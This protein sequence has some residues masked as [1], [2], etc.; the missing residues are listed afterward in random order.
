LEEIKRKE[1]LK[2]KENQV[3]AE[4]IMEKK[5][6]IQTTN[7]KSITI[8]ENTFKSI[9]IENPTTKTISISKPNIEPIIITKPNGIIIS[10]DAD[11]AQRNSIPTEMNIQT[12]TENILTLQVKEP[13]KQ[14][15]HFETFQEN[16]MSQKQFT[17][18]TIFTEGFIP[19]PENPKQFN[20]WEF[21]QLRKE[22]H[23]G[24]EEIEAKEV[25]YDKEVPKEMSMKLRKEKF[26]NNQ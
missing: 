17:K 7:I 4:I 8:G 23:D 22:S 25:N 16:S 13:G 15:N 2:K 24:Y 20:K 10:K 19:N 18:T 11:E 26:I 21:I 14:N 3:K 9:C 12:P 5:P 1:L 6:T